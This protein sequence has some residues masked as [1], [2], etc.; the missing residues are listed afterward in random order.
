MAKII[1][2]DKDTLRPIGIEEKEV[3]HKKIQE[4]F[5]A[6]KEQK[7]IH[8]HM[9]ALITD[10]NKLLIGIRPY[11]S[12]T[13]SDLLDKTIGGHIKAGY[14]NA[15]AILEITTR[16]LQIPIAVVSYKELI[17][18]T[19]NHPEL[20][21]RQAFIT[22]IGYQDNFISKRICK[23]TYEEQCIQY[24]YLGIYNGL[25]KC[26]KGSGIRTF[27][28][29]H[30]IEYIKKYPER[31]TDD[32]KNIFKNY[33]H[34]IETLFESIKKTKE[35]KKTKELIEINDMDGN[36]VTLED[37]KT[38]HNSIKKDF[39]NKEKQKLKHSHIG[40]LL[41]GNSGEIYVQIRAE[42]KS[43]NPKKYDKTVG[44]HISAGDTPTVSCY[45]EFIEEMNIP[46][47]MH[48]KP[49]FLNILK[50]CKDIIKTQAICQKP[51]LV[52]NFVSKR[53]LKDGTFFEEICD[54]YFIIGYYD[55]FFKLV[56]SE[57]GGMYQFENR[58]VL[59]QEIEKNPDDFTDDIKFLLKYFWDDLISLDE[60]L[61]QKI[62][63]EN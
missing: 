59:K 57:A 60:K 4:D 2:Y 62:I 28:V 23:K 35:V 49:T 21:E 25:Y 42:N 50:N 6:K 20:L 38:V 17:D 41:I 61:K 39:K 63:E 14:E 9:G 18:I 3:I 1:I 10:I 16:E 53:I 8:T 22:E 24:T 31:I 12:E 13:N 29:E 34:Q 37:R 27:S 26:E 36:F 40:G 47:S 56:D 15:S 11:D 30:F 58:E 19:L 46:I 52:K 32:I 43:E 33:L 5:L 7:S 51:V 45:H 44:G 55:G 54:Q 48:D